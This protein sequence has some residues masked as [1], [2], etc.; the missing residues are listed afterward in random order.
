MRGRAPRYRRGI[1]PSAGGAIFSAGS[2]PWGTTA[3]SVSECHIGQPD[4]NALP[5]G[6]AVADSLIPGDLE[7]ALAI[8]AKAEELAQNNPG[9]LAKLDILGNALKEEAAKEA[10][11]EISAKVAGKWSGTSGISGNNVTFDFKA[12][13][14][15]TCSAPIAKGIHRWK[16]DDEMAN[17]AITDNDKPIFLF[18]L[19]VVDENWVGRFVERGGNWR[20]SK[21][22]K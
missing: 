20:I 16:V 12:S 21:Q 6:F 13:G 4:G 1:N 3:L 11:K 19:P 22:V 15:V 14:Q 8:K 18:P 2:G 9:G 7:L 17:V 10:M 5:N